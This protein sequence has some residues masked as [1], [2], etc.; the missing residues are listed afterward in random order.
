MVM[1]STVIPIEALRRQIASGVDIIVHLGRLRDKSR[2]VLEIREITG[3]SGTDIETRMLYVFRETGVKDGKIEGQ[4]EIKSGL[5][6]TE[7]LIKRGFA[8]EEEE[9]PS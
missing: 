9:I 5:Y 1:L 8:I 3:M 2:H 4:L 7:K 6:N